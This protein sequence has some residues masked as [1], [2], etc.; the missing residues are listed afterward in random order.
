MTSGNGSHKGGSRRGAIVQVLTTLYIQWPRRHRLRRHRKH[1]ATAANRRSLR[2]SY[3][4]TRRR[5]PENPPGG[6]SYADWHTWM[7]S[8]RA[9]QRCCPARLAHHRQRPA[10][11]GASSRRRDEADAGAVRGGFSTTS[12]SSRVRVSIQPFVFGF[13]GNSQTPLLGGLT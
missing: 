9:N 7:R 3:P 6:K 4:G 10:G 8:Y 13:G 2:G 1:G 11:Q 12:I 5:L